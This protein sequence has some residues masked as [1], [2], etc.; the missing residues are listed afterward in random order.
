LIGNVT[1]P[2]LGRSLDGP[3]AAH[4]AVQSHQ[5]KPVGRDATHSGATTAY[6]RP[7]DLLP[8]HFLLELA[9]FD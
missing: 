9:V 4:L 8:I 2:T 1:S 3:L 6:G 7:I 5:W